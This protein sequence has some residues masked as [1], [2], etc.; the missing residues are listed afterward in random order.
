[1]KKII[2]L[3]AILVFVSNAQ[4]DTTVSLAFKKNRSHNTNSPEFRPPTDLVKIY[5][6]FILTKKANLG[7][8]VAQ[9]ELGVRYLV[10]SGLSSDTS[11]SFYWIKKAADNNFAMA[12]FNAGIFYNNGWGIDWNPFTAFE[13]FLLAAENNFPEAQF[14]VGIT[15]SENLIVKQDLKQAYFWIKKAAEN[16]FEPAIQYLDDFSKKGIKNEVDAQNY[17]DENIKKNSESLFHLAYIDF[18]SNDTLKVIPDSIIISE[19]ARILEIEKDAK[20][21]GKKPFAKFDSFT[22]DTLLIIRMELEAEFGSPEAFN[23]IGKLYEKGIYYKK[24]LIKAAMCY[25]RAFRLDS[26]LGHRLLVNLLN[27]KEFSSLMK[28]SAQSGNKDA[29]YVWAFLILNS[30]D[31]EL[32]SSDAVRMLTENASLNHIPSII[33]LGIIYYRA[34]GVNKDRERA[35]HF[36]QFASDLGS[37]EAKMRYLTDKVLLTDGKTDYTEIISTLKNGIMNNSILAQVV[38]GLC[39]ETGRGVVVDYAKA[40]DL[41]RDAAVRGSITG[42]ESLKR[43]L[44]A[45]RPSKDLFRK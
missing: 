21:G 5:D 44:N 2:C 11:K 20:S 19:V 1:L 10:G 6:S 16:K 8:P 36:W 30:F 33:E 45:I 38:M 32:L 18:T 4:V 17:A 40:S 39:Y 37:N 22:E 34:T 7:D 23:Y 41:Y 24:D 14:A 12:Q 31:S 35:L 26:I 28:S 3:I 29:K 27:E 9:H 42:F 25:I 43:L 15:Y 13:Y